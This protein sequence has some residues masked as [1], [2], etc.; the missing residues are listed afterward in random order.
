MCVLPTG[1]FSDVPRVLYLEG[2]DS[3]G[4]EGSVAVVPLVVDGLMKSSLLA[5][6]PIGCELSGLEMDSSLSPARLAYHS[7]EPK[8]FGL[9]MGSY[10]EMDPTPLLCHPVASSKAKR[11]STEWVIQLVEEVSLLWGFCATGLRGSY[12]FFMLIL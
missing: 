7:L 6:I 12:Q 11:G 4:V 9:E 8:S 2:K 3:S 10:L 1:L 5:P